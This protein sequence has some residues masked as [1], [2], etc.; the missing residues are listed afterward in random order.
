MVRHEAFDKGQADMKI[1]V[2]EDSVPVRE[3]LI[4]MIGEIGGFELV[5]D[6]ATFDEAVDGIRRTKPDIA[7]FDIQLAA[8]SGIDALAEVKRELPGLRAVVLTNYA[9]PQHEKASADAGAEY[10]LD[11]SADFEKIAEIL[12]SMKADQDADRR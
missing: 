6:A 3:R 8:G 7:I 1:F 12:E 11:K 2:V 9:T 10:F 4:E 5:G